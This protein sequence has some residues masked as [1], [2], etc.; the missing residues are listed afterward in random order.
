M[1]IPLWF[2]GSA[3]FP[4]SSRP[5]HKLTRPSAIVSSSSHS[6]RRSED[7]TKRA[8]GGATETD[9]SS[10][11]W[12]I[13]LPLS[14]CGVSTALASAS[15]IPRDLRVFHESIPHTTGMTHQKE[16][17]R[18]Q[19]ERTYWARSTHPHQRPPTLPDQRAPSTSTAWGLLG[20]VKFRTAMPRSHN[21]E[22][23]TVVMHSSDKTSD[24]RSR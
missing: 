17:L 7:S 24:L 13:G 22:N 6:S 2:P 14:I 20:R 15:R 12:A 3:E 18:D 8:G 4:H 21:N 10:L 9:T 23:A 19:N 1:P 5:F 11:S 16:S